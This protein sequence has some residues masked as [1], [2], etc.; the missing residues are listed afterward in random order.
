MTRFEIMDTLIDGYGNTTP[1]PDGV[2]VFKNDTYQVWVRKIQ[3]GLFGDVG[4]LSI[5]RLDR[6]PIRDWRDL[7]R[8]KNEICGPEC[9]GVELYPA[10]SRLVDTSNQY[11]LFVF[12]PG[13]RLPFGFNERLVMEAKGKDPLIARAEQRPWS[14]EDRPSDLTDPDEAI[15][16]LR[17]ESP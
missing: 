17:G 13:V 7:Q 11:H 12:Q 8:I 4:W 16:K 1:V 5:K 10:E 9:E 3:A 14:D 2:I 6:Q 15:A